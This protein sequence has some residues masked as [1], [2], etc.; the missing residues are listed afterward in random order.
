MELLIDKEFLLKER[1]RIYDLILSSPTDL[2]L[3]EERYRAIHIINFKISYR[4]GRCG[5]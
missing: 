4:Y 2:A 5:Y 3:L 1:E